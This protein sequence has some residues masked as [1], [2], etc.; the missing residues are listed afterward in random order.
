[1]ARP[2][3][4]ALAL[5]IVNPEPYSLQEETMSTAIVHPVPT[6]C[7]P[8]VLRIAITAAI[9]ALVLCA[10]CPALTSASA[11]PGPADEELPSVESVLKR[12]VEAV[13]GRDAIMGLK[14]RTASMR[15]VTDLQWDR[16]I[17]EVDTLT[18]YGA[19]DGRFLVV[20]QSERGTMLEGFDGSEEW[21]VDPGGMVSL[22]LERGPRDGWVTDPLFPLK[23]R[24][25]F[26]DME[27]VGADTWGTD[28]GGQQ[29]LYVV[30]VDD[31]ESH[32]LGFEVDTGLLVRLGYNTEIRDYREVDGVLVPMQVAYSRKGGSSTYFIDSVKHNERIDGTVFSLAK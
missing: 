4:E 12:Y 5:L 6:R 27:V 15:R 17:H 29:H 2:A 32:H 10:A 22:S 23:L 31:D 25:Y 19:S 30:A 18:V 20:T 26:P 1:V 9:T 13:G 11:N 16:Y 14:T 7:T 8:A 3:V 21:K 24:Q 28:L